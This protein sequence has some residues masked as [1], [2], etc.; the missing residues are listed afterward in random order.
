MLSVFVILGTDA[1]QAVFRDPFP[2][3]HPRAR[4]LVVSP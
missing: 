4:P 3:P 1:K 2:P